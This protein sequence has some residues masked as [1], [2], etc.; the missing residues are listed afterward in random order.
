MKSVKAF[1]LL[2]L[3]A[4]DSTAVFADTVA[5]NVAGYKSEGRISEV[6]MI[7]EAKEIIKIFALELQQRLKG[8]LQAN[9]PISAIRVCNVDAPEIENKYSNHEWKISRTS[10]K[11]RNPGNKPDQWENDMLLEFERR[12]ASGEALS[13]LEASSVTETEFRFIKAIP[14]A[15][16]CTVCHGEVLGSEISEELYHLYPGDTARGF[17]V[18]DIRGAF[19]LRKTL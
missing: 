2:I 16:V 3:S 13:T 8:E 17:S 10:L 12:L 11:T 5:D 4:L 19:S 18:G 6:I 9:G 7:K 15:E 14:T 1:I